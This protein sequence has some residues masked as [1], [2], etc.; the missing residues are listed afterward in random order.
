M[1]SEA[2]RNAWQGRPEENRKGRKEVRG[3]RRSPAS[4]PKE[5]L[6]LS[7]DCSASGPRRLT[8][9]KTYTAVARYLAQSPRPVEQQRKSEVSG[10]SN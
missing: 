9:D 10:G 2:K 7:D 8:R 5:S 4:P 3:R 6:V 1:Q